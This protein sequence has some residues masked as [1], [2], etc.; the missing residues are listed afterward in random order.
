MAKVL[1]STGIQFKAASNATILGV[2]EY[3]DDHFINN[4]KG[5]LNE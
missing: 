2:S 4:T 3:S 5:G 1:L